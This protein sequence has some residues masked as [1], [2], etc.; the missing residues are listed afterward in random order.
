MLRFT[1]IFLFTF[2]GCSSTNTSIFDFFPQ[3]S[4]S[5][6]IIEYKS[7]TGKGILKSKG[8]LNGKLSFTFKSQR[9][10]TF[11]DF[12]DPIGR[13]T[14]LVWVTKDSIIARNLIE[15][16]QYDNSDVMELLPVL[17]ALEPNDITK[18][19]WG[20][21]PEQ[22]DKK[23][24]WDENDFVMEFYR[25]NLGNEKRALA[26]I[27]FDDSSLNSSVKM[28]IKTRNRNLDFVDMKKVWRLLK[29]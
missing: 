14:L 2:L 17:R 20:A 24:L 28:D 4:Y 15:N 13:K 11:L 19:I 25:K 29:Y 27:Y 6:Y 10:S 21:K 9:D 26:G 3:K 1:I 8:A 12:S 18:I 22:K 5:E 23:E 7:C 16:R